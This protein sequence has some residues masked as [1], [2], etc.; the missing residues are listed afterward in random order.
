MGTKTKGDF[1]MFIFWG[2]DEGFY[3]DDE[4]FDEPIV[5]V[6]ERIAGRNYRIRLTK[7]ELEIV[8]DA[9]ECGAWDEFLNDVR[10]NGWA[11]TLEKWT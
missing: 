6:Y 8:N 7:E 3:F 11:N 5:R 2:A 4:I 1:E 10:E 9:H